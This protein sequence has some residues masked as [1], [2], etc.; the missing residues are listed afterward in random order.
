MVGSER[1]RRGFHGF[2]VHSSLSIESTSTHAWRWARPSKGSS[3][4]WKPDR[5]AVGQPTLSFYSL[6][7]ENRLCFQVLG[8]LARG[9]DSVTIDGR[10]GVC[11]NACQIRRILSIRRDDLSPGVG[12]FVTIFQGTGAPTGNKRTTWPQTRA[13]RSIC[14]MCKTPSFSIVWWLIVQ[15]RRDRDE[16]VEMMP[17]PKHVTA[18]TP[19]SPIVPRKYC[20]TR[21]GCTG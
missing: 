3:H 5:D 14:A 16:A 2:T 19:M 1:V 20:D 21:T 7:V 18:T 12:F 11:L 10:F 17:M 8:S 9:I 13:S 6:G 15:G 4:H